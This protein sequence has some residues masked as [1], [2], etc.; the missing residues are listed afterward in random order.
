[1]HE[2]G[3]VRG[4]SVTSVHID[5]RV[6]H[7]RER[8]THGR[9][10]CGGKTA[11]SELH[12]PLGLNFAGHHYRNPR[13]RCRRSI[14][15]SVTPSSLFPAAPSSQALTPHDTSL[16]HTPLR[17]RV[18]LSRFPALAL[19]A[20]DSHSLA[21]KYYISRI[22]NGPDPIVSYPTSSLYVP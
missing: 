6:C 14:T 3:S 4:S 17:I 8:S 13:R 9:P 10:R 1:M 12:F 19:T 16:L 5:S 15:I 21:Y 2:A 20:P 22:T 7:C 11:A 18:A